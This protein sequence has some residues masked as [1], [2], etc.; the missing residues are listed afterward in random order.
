[1]PPEEKT[2]EE[3]FIPIIMDKINRDNFYRSVSNI[4]RDIC[5][6]GEYNTN[7]LIFDEYYSLLGYK[8]NE[9]S[10]EQMASEMMIIKFYQ[11]L[12]EKNKKKGEIF[13]YHKIFNTIKK[14]T[15]I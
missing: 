6:N 4:I 11:Y 15:L 1:M 9:V 10:K 12:S 3:W 8:P 13:Q 5:F 14:N 7:S 2:R